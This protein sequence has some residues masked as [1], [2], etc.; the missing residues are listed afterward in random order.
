MDTLVSMVVATEHHSILFIQEDARVLQ[1]ITG[2][3]TNNVHSTLKITFDLVSK[4]VDW[5][6]LIIMA[7][8]LGVAVAI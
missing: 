2:A 5:E 6:T 7:S 1:S 8:V 4:L 3:A